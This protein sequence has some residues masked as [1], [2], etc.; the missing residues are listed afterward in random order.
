MEKER[1]KTIEEI[2]NVEEISVDVHLFWESVVVNGEVLC[3]LL[4]SRD[5]KDD[6]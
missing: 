4:C 1:S 2:R 5:E 3:V 6:I